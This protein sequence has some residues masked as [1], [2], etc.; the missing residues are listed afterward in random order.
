MSGSNSIFGNLFQDSVIPLTE[1]VVGFT[2]ARQNV[3][4]GNIA[5]LD[6]PGYQTRDLDVDTF[7]DQLQAVVEARREPDQSDPAA[8]EKANRNLAEIAKNPESILRHDKSNVGMEGQVSVM[9]KNQIE[10]NL[11]LTIMNN[12][13]QLLEA[14]IRERF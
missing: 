7:R 12:Q 11:A 10:H 4:A 1:Q 5:N 13:L 3:L 6:T 8:V 2:Q 14:A 9:V